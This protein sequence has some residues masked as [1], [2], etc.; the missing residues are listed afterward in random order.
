MHRALI[1]VVQGQISHL[2][3]TYPTLIIK[4]V[5]MLELILVVPMERLCLGRSLSSSLL[6][7]LVNMLIYGPLVKGFLR[8]D[9]SCSGNFKSV[10]A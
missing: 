10:Q 4:L 2:D 7:S 3:E 5:Y 6:I 8:M 9:A 1:T